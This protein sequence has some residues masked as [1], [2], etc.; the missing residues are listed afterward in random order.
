MGTEYVVVSEPSVQ[1]INIGAAGPQGAP[2]DVT[3]DDNFSTDG[4]IVV[5]KGSTGN[6][7]RKFTLAGL[8]KSNSGI[9][10]IAQPN[11]DYIPV[12]NPAFT[13]NIRST[14]LGTENFVIDASTNSRQITLGVFRIEHK[15]GIPGTRPITLD[16]DSNG[17]GN[18]RAMVVNY[19]AN[20][21]VPGGE[22][23]IY[24]LIID[25]TGTT[26][27]TAQGFSVART[28]TGDADVTA[29]EA[30]SGVNV[31][32]QYVGDPLSLTK[33]WKLSNTTY[34]DTTTDF[35]NGSNIQIFSLDNDYIICGADSIFTQLDIELAIASSHTI[36][37]IFQY[38]TGAGT[39]NTFNPSD[40]TNGFTKSGAISWQTLSGWVSADV[41][42][43][44]KYYIRIQRTRNN[45]TTPPTE[46]SIRVRSTTEFEWDK[47]GDVSVR[48]LK[49]SGLPTY[50]DRAA[51]QTGGLVT[52][53][54]YQTLTGQLMIV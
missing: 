41:N 15:A 4:E 8:L 37:A 26:G 25:T 51:A 18:T 23:H 27:G 21:L 17:F 29:L 33:A 38:S 49:A 6:L 30:Y 14:L 32:S 34:T 45:I 10:E 44:S 31:L 50:A 36:D 9:L 13:G 12:N 5:L 52:G 53:Q 22:S 1:V 16:I 46:S 19:I 39:W 47:N 11:I 24:D 54:F 20:G 42:G 7:L 40:G 28:G 2:G 35:S 48:K 43:V 3:T